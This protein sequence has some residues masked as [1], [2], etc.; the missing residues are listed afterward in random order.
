VTDEN[1]LS[2]ARA[3]LAKATAALQATYA[4]S[5]LALYDDAASRLY[6]AVFHL[7]SAALM[8]LGLQAQSHGGVAVLLGKHLIGPGLLPVHVGRDFAML[9]GLRSQAD[10]N[11]H[12]S[13]DADSF[14]SEL[15]RAEALF[16][17]IG[18]FLEARG[19][20]Q[21]REPVAR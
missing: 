16:S 19:V 21:A 10:Y 17:L 8:S 20:S 9:M 2:N 13:L 11:R 15:A 4:L 1:A 14:Q 6:Y 3:E 5:K 18:Q 7:V 12:F